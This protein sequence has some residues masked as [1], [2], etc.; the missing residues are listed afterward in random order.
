LGGD[1][2]SSYNGD[3]PVI[4]VIS[5][6]AGGDNGGVEAHVNLDH[7]HTMYVDDAF[8]NG[9]PDSTELAVETYLEE[10]I[11]HG[12]LPGTR[13]GDILEDELTRILK[14]GNS[15]KSLSDIN[16]EWQSLSPEI[17]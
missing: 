12:V 1:V 4:L 11:L 9:D 6:A 15:T 8:L 7:I 10:A 17:D 5:R 3:E 16:P 2:V 14:D 13:L